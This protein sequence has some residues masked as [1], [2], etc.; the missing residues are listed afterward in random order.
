MPPLSPKKKSKVFVLFTFYRLML[1]VKGLGILIEIAG[2]SFLLTAWIEQKTQEDKWKGLAEK[3]I[4]YRNENLHLANKATLYSEQVDMYTASL[5]YDSTWRDTSTGKW[6]MAHL[7]SLAASLNPTAVMLKYYYKNIYQY[8]RVFDYQRSNYIEM[9]GIDQDRKDTLQYY[10]LNIWQLNK[11]ENR[12]ERYFNEKKYDSL[13]IQYGLYTTK[14]NQIFKQYT[15]DV[16]DAESM[17][18]QKKQKSSRRYFKFYLLGTISIGVSLVLKN[19][20]EYDKNTIDKNTSRTI[21]F[22]RFLIRFFKKLRRD[23][24]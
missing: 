13:R 15:K 24:F 12:I 22:T 1:S 11:D 7:D 16:A 6:I 8:C 14:G 9:I 4:T 2:F 17:L 10:W 21:S 5:T 3:E 20:K 23:M 19:L 18:I